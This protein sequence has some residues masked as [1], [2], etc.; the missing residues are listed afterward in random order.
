MR[1]SASGKERNIHALPLLFFIK[2]MA[3]GGNRV[4]VSVAQSVSA[5]GC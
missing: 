1:E 4:G 2:V 3:G 5:F